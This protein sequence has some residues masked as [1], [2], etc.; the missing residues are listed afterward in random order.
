MLLEL[1][2]LQSP[3]SCWPVKLLLM[4]PVLAFWS[5][6]LKPLDFW[7]KLQSHWKLRESGMIVP[8]HIQDEQKCLFPTQDCFHISNIVLYLSI[9]AH[10]QSDT[11]GGMQVV[12]SQSTKKMKK[13]EATTPVISRGGLG[14]KVPAAHFTTYTTPHYTMYTT[15]NKS[16]GVAHLAASTSKTSFIRRFSAP[17]GRFFRL[18]IV[19]TCSLAFL[20]CHWPSPP[21]N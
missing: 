6:Q 14:E 7:V 10:L 20:T 2:I 9:L 21:S 8:Y 1:E 19:L 13:D 11:I 5:S 12:G 17:Q 4:K 16:V 18:L 15:P 3:G